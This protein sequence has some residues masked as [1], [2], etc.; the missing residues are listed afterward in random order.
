[1]SKAIEARI[2]TLVAPIVSRAD[3]FLESVTVTR[4]KEPLV[5][6]TVDLKEGAGSVD[7]DDVLQV[8]REISAA[9]D[10]ADP[11]ESAYTLEVSTPGAERKLETPRHFSRCIG[12]LV[13]IK[14]QDG[15][16]LKGRVV[17]SDDQSVTLSIAGKKVKPEREE[18]VALDKITKAHSRVD[19]GSLGK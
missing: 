1:M 5:R 18:A 10:E 9:M 17:S 15:E 4:G 8:S 19:F 3:L 7:A 11:I 2:E 16:R 6:V 13:E 14:T 12:H